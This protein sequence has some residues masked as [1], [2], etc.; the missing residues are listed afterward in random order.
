M[1]ATELQQ[2]Q[3]HLGSLRSE[4]LSALTPF[5]IEGGLGF[6]RIRDEQ[7]LEMSEVST[8]TC[9]IS[10][11]HAH[12]WEAWF[13]ILKEVEGVDLDTWTPEALQAR[14]VSPEAWR[15]RSFR[16]T[17][18]DQDPDPNPYHVAFTTEAALALGEPRTTQIRDRL[19][20]AAEY[21]VAEIKSDSIGTG[22]RPP[23]EPGAIS[24]QF[25]PSAHLTQL[26]V[27]VLR[28]IDDVIGTSSLTEVDDLCREWA[29]KRLVRHMALRQAG[30]RSADHYE[31]A[32]AAAILASF[33]LTELA[34]DEGRLVSAALEDVFDAQRG[35][36]LWPLSHPLFVHIN[37]GTAYSYEYEMLSQLLQEPELEEI[38]LRH[39]DPFARAAD[40]LRY[41]SYDLAG[42]RAWSSGHIPQQRSPESWATASVYQFAYDLS[43]LAAEATRRTL[44]DVIGA[45][46]HKAGP[47]RGPE[48]LD[49][50][51]PGGDADSLKQ[52]MDSRV[53]QPLIESASA[54]RRGQKLPTKVP[55]SVVLFGPPGTAK[56]TMARVIAHKLGWPLI[57]IDPSHIVGQG[58]DRVQESAN[59]ILG[60]VA[61]A[62]GV[63]VLLD[64]FDELMRSRD[65]DRSEL[66][67]RFLTTAMLPKL[68]T[69]HDAR[70]V[71]FIVATNHVDFFDTAITRPGR[72]DALIPLLAPSLPEKL[73]HPEWSRVAP[74]LQYLTT[75]DTEQ[76]D[77]IF[78]AENLTF[79]EYS[80]FVDYLSA[81]FADPSSVD[82]PTVNQILTEH[83]RRS[84]AFEY[85]KEKAT[86]YGI[87]DDDDIETR[88]RALNRILEE[89]RLPP[90]RN[91][92]S[93]N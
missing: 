25:P 56:T 52:T 87:H 49:A 71:F 12:S 74:A 50:P 81:S 23:S 22:D 16:P 89:R 4:H 30:G 14:L 88:R 33:G 29:F 92:S 34:P 42:S 19:R 37:I 78:M 57:K 28:R 45:E 3:A 11:C 35:D 39:L 8:A 67:S 63:V 17:P 6:K 69:I 31:E 15:S 38:L 13:Q 10:I 84:A 51:L 9:V 93:A 72:I 47:L 62:E 48:I 58:L 65:E 82:A 64:E 36:G 83:W 68:A 60:L 27:R 54:V 32:Y 7:R 41:D 73:A 75:N 86:R 90:P 76:S 5:V 1:E 80:Q 85:L 77:A 59:T 61:R 66:V 2:L 40:A 21:L 26:A 70:S 44:F 20:E 79:D 55:V 43:R 24:V 18:P 53:I 91:A 46:Y